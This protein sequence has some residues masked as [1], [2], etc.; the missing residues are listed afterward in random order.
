MKTVPQIYGYAVCLVAIICLL[1]VT[2]QIGKAWYDLRHPLPNHEAMP[3]HLVSYQLFRADLL[4]KSD[5]R[6]S[7]LGFISGQTNVWELYQ[8]A[9]QAYD[10]AQAQ[11]V[12]EVRVR[13]RRT[14]TE[15]GFLGVA[16]LLIFAA[17]VGWL[18]RQ[19][20]RAV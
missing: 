9:R 6:L 3:Q 12:E 13:A 4:A 7:A 14:L 2:A 8:Q 11:R 5:A 16:S 10:N 19:V 18:S 17:H 20:R 1:M 15:Y